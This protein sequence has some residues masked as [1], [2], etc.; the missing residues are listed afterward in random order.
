MNSEYETKGQIFIIKKREENGIL[1]PKLFGP[2]V[3]KKNVLVIE[4]NF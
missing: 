4:K 1:L 2:T 3:R